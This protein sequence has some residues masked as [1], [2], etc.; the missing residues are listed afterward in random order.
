MR[1]IHSPAKEWK[2][3]A[4]FR[5]KRA[6]HPTP[7]AGEDVSYL[8]CSNSRQ[9]RATGQKHDD[10][11]GGSRAGHGSGGGGSGE[12]DS[13]GGERDDGTCRV[14]LDGHGHQDR[15]PGQL[16]VVLPDPAAGDTADDDGCVSA[17]GERRR[18]VSDL[19]AGIRMPGGEPG[20]HPGR[21]V[22]LQLDG[23]GE[24]P[25]LR[26]RDRDHRH[27]LAVVCPPRIPLHGQGRLP[28]YRPEHH[29][30]H[31]LLTA[32]HAQL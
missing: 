7:A 15:V 3:S 24:W 10:N 32:H 9:G 17:R 14:Q 20:G 1:V 8:V 18:G 22:G 11:N 21:G 26:V 29:R 2:H 23:H 4:R 5:G 19:R 30:R 6:R 12:R 27:Q 16:A 25:S 13:G 28:V 31:C